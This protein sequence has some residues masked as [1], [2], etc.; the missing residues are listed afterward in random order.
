[1]YRAYQQNPE[2]VAWW[3]QQEY[4]KLRAEAAQVSGTI[5]FA[6]EAGV[7]SD[8]HA[9]T[10]WAPVGNTPVVAAAAEAERGA[11]QEGVPPAVDG[12]MGGRRD[13]AV[14]AAGIRPVRSAREAASQDD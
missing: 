10:T 9:G 8:Y 5:Y 12:R 11:A 1:M 4:P 2:A 7:R 14:G 3:K 6:D 13:E